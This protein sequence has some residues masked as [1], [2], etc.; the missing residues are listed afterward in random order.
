M[1]H[2]SHLYHLLEAR[3]EG[4]EVWVIY[5]ATEHPLVNLLRVRE[6]AERGGHD[7]PEDRIEHRYWKS[8]QN[9]PYALAVSD[10]AQVFDN[11]DP[12]EP[13]KLLFEMECGRT[14]LRRTLPDMP[15]WAVPALSY[16]RA[17]WEDGTPSG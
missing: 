14:I 11:S 7:V 5:V 2:R 1:S 17:E 12:E 3:D 9:L 6:R 10:Y 15:G 8:L 13:F 16:F 4:Y